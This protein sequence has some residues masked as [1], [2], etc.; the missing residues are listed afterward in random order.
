MMDDLSDAVKLGKPKRLLWDRMTEQPELGDRFSRYMR[1]FAQ[2]LAPDLMRLADLP[3]RPLRL[4]DL[5]GSHGTHSV[6]FC[7]RFPDLQAVIVDLEAAL[8][9][10]GSRIAEA[11]FADRISVRSGDIRACDWGDE[12]YDLALYLSVAHNMSVDENRK[13]LRHLARAL[14]RDGVLIIHDYPRD[15]TPSLFEA[16]F[17]LTLLVETG[18]RTLTRAEFT[19]LLQDAGFA[20]H[21]LHV[22]SPA[23]KGSLI[24]A[25]R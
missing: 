8:T 24:V 25:R 4:L 1:A 19:E 3:T 10:T 17:R 20:S 18:T 15:T 7:K 9:D 23:E 11:G 16:A 5:G 2:H 22:L 13:I 6:A 21:H 14:R 12:G